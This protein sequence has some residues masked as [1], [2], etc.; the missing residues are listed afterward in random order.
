MPPPSAASEVAAEVDGGTF[1]PVMPAPTG[2]T[3]PASVPTG[4]VPLTAHV[5]ETRRR[6]HQVGLDEPGTVPYA[7]AGELASN[8]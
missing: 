4:L 8:F 1:I 5:T 6:I 2:H 7:L 3:C